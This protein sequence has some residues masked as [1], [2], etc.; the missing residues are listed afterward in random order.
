M[1]EPTRGGKET[2]ADGMGPPAIERSG[3][4]RNRAPICG[5]PGSMAEGRGGGTGLRREKAIRPDRRLLAREE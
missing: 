1:G 3:G 4:G 2:M 5:T